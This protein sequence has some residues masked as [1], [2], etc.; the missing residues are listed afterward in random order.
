MAIF[1]AMVNG[2]RSRSF[3]TAV[4]HRFYT[5]GRYS[6][7]LRPEMG[8]LRKPIVCILRVTRHA[9]AWDPAAVTFAPAPRQCPAGQDTTA[10]STSH[11]STTVGMLR[12]LARRS[13]GPATQRL[14]G[15]S[16]L[17]KRP[18]WGGDN[19]LKALQARDRNESR[20]GNPL[21]YRRQIR[22]QARVRKSKCK[23]GSRSHR[24]RRRRW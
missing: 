17:K 23:A 9:T 22:A 21:G 12:S 2:R 14:W 16:H 6:I 13:R 1:C 5:K 8:S 19:T 3:G 24:M 10:R 18:L 4:G 11:S 20:F 15:V 7:A